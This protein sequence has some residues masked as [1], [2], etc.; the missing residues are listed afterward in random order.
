VHGKGIGVLSSM[1]SGHTGLARIT[2]HAAVFIFGLLA[3]AVA[4]LELSSENCPG[5]CAVTREGG[6]GQGPVLGD[7]D[8]HSLAIFK[9]HRVFMEPPQHVPARL[10]E[11]Q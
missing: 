11:L 2:S 4:L 7:A 3:V 8:S 6:D 10:A 9:I 5:L 1:P